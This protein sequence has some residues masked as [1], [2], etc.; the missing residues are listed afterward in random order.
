MWN[1]IRAEFN[2]KI[3]PFY[4][5]L[6]DVEISLSLSGVYY[7]YAGVLKMYFYVIYDE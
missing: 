7:M 3:F 4:K 6:K 1:T 5:L 2:R